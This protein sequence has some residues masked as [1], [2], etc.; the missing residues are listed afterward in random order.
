MS[1]KFQTL[2]DWISQAVSDPDKT[3]HSGEAKPCT[4]LAVLYVKQNGV[5]TDSVYSVSLTGASKGKSPSE[6]AD[7]FQSRIQGFA[8]GFG[9]GTQTFRMIAFYGSDKEPQASH[10]LRTLDGDLVLSDDMAPS[11]APT[12]KGILAQL[13]RHL[14]HKDSMIMDFWRATVADAVR[15]RRELQ[16]E[17][18]ESYKIVREMMMNMEGSRHQQ[19]MEQEQY[20]RTSQE[21]KALMGMVPAI[22]NGLTGKEIF[23]KESANKVLVETLAR[24]LTPD[25]VEGLVAM[26]IIPKELQGVVVARILEVRERDEAE[27]REL[28]RVPPANRDG[29]QDVQG[30]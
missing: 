13:M 26:G 17:V 20:A 19:R 11:E 15:D 22:A 5:G 8:Q 27:R 1:R 16:G 29:S 14:E 25:Q 4:A 24:K 30:N 3:T 12:E 7:A 10:N 28:A 6:L 9:K 23:P 21:R 18:N 2:E